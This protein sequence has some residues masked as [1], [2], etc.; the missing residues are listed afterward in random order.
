MYPS[1]NPS[2]SFRVLCQ[3]RSHLLPTQTITTK[4]PQSAFSITHRARSDI[5]IRNNVDYEGVLRHPVQTFP[6]WF[7]KPGFRH[8]TNGS[9]VSKGQVPRC[10]RIQVRSCVISSSQKHSDRRSEEIKIDL[11]A[12]V[13]R[14]TRSQDPWSALRDRSRARDT[15][16]VSLGLD[17]SL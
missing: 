6:E 15:S 11:L 1:R 2:Y 16:S 8:R 12:S 14:Y 3:T 10:G 17:L 13:V 5:Y 9:W 7:S 4:H